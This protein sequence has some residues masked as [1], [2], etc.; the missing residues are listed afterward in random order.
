MTEKGLELIKKF[1][2]CRLTA[3]KCP[4]NKWTIGYGATHYADGRI[5]QEGD[6]LKSESEAEELLKTMVVPYENSVDSCVKSKINP[7]QRDALTSFAY[8]LGPDN[9]KS[10]TLLK[11]VNLNPNDITIRNEFAKWVKAKGKVLTGLVN[12]RK[13]EAD[14]YFTEWTEPIPDHNDS[15]P[16]GPFFPS[17]NQN[18]VSWMY[19]YHSENE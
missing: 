16:K 4:A 17:Q 13:A 1:E 2:G 10:S 11:K 12:R 19:Q 8:N 7:Y 9:L 14:L 15:D 6:K 3:Y 18:N 5:V